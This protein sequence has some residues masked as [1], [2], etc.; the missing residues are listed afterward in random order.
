MEE[1]ESIIDGDVGTIANEES[2]PQQEE[3]Y[4]PPPTPKWEAP[5]EPPVQP[6]YNGQD[7]DSPAWLYDPDLDLQTYTKNIVEEAGN[8]FRQTLD[9]E[10]LHSRVERA[11]TRAMEVYSGK[12]GLPSYS[13]LV[14]GYA[15]PAMR[16]RPDLRQLILAQDDPATAAYV[17]GFCAAYPHLIPQVVARQGKI[18]KTIFQSTHFRPTV[19][20][21]NSGR[22]Q[23]SEK[24]NY[25]DWDNES[26]EAELERFKN[27]G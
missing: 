9:Q 3:S 13:E 23:P 14:D 16:S 26:F 18:D 1:F 27:Y 24:T 8:R 19:Q 7:D 12:D 11:E 2:P 4:T 6:N 5:Y 22:R 17:V 20:G 10:R 15:V 25:N 21:R